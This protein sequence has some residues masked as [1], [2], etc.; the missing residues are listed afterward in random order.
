MAA[1]RR[2]KHDSSINA[3]DARLFHRGILA[4]VD[5][6]PVLLLEGFLYQTL[7]GSTIEIVPW[8]IV[9]RTV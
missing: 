9:K 7:L 6:V 2:K 5:A 3:S 4:G 8:G 1:S